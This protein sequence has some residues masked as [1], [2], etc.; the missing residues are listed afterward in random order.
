MNPPQVEAYSF[1]AY[2]FIYHDVGV[3]M[4]LTMFATCQ[5][6]QDF[7]PSVKHSWGA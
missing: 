2:V 4:V 1:L 3:H 5:V 7:G 6:M